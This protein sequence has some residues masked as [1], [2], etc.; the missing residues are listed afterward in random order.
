MAEVTRVPIQ[1]IAKGSVLKLWLGLLLVVAL[2]AG[3]AYWAMPKGVEVSEITAGEGPNPVVGDVVFVKY[4]GKLVDGTVFDKSQDM[5]LPVQGILPEGTP[6]TLDGVIPGFKEA[7][8]KMQKGGKYEVR[9]PADKAYGASPPP[10]SPIPPN[11]DLI[12]EME[13]IDF[14]PEADAQRRVQ[15]IQQLMAGQQQQGEGEAPPAGN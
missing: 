1:P 12:F 3:L 8:M 13:L 11:S 2:A 5:Q 14:M 15:M 6:M 7:L 4:T 10:G 9:I